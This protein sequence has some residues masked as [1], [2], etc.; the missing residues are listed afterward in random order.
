M[1]P[2]ERKEAMLAKIAE[3][4]QRQVTSPRCGTGYHVDVDYP[5]ATGVYCAPNSQDAGPPM[6]S[7]CAPGASVTRWREAFG[8]PP[9]TR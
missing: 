5:T 6:V 9:A 4:C 2:R 1:T 3:L 8:L 7:P